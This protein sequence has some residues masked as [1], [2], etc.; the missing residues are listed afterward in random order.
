MSSIDETRARAALGRLFDDILMPASEKLR[1][2][3]ALPFPLKPDAARDSYY[4][5]RSSRRMT[6]ADFVFPS[7]VG[8]SDLTQR[9]EA[10]WR[11]AERHELAA[12]APLIAEAAEAARAARSPEDDDSDVSGTTY[13]MF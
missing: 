5:S 4:V 2:E 13:V 10:F 12:A 8:T 7:T 3:D 11:S 9:L 1:A 6:R